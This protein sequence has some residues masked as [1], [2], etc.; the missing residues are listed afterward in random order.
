[1]A[2]KRRKR[3]S[4]QKIAANNPQIFP[5]E[6]AF[7]AHIYFHTLLTIRGEGERAILTM[8]KAQENWA[9]CAS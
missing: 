9:F 3:E 8:K 2:S 5:Q 1:V 7:T 6:A 4:S